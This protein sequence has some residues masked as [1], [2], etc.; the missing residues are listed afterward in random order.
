MKKPSTRRHTRC[1]VGTGWPCLGGVGVLLSITG[2]TAVSSSPLPCQSCRQIVR[3]NQRRSADRRYQQSERGRRSHCRRQRRYRER[4]AQARVTD[5][6]LKPIVAWP[7]PHPPCLYA[8]AFCGRSSL[9]ITPY[10][11]IPRRWLA[12]SPAGQVGARSKKYAFR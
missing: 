12:F 2:P 10:E 5:Q 8:C 7:P 9:W 4:Q 1:A 11:P 6:P 3:R